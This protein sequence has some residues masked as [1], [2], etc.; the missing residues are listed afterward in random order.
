[1]ELNGEF[2]ILMNRSDDKK[3]VKNFK[4]VFGRSL[5]K[6]SDKSMLDAK[7]PFTFKYFYFD[8]E[9]AKALYIEIEPNQDEKGTF[10]H[11]GRPDFGW[12]L[13]YRIRD[14]FDDV[15]KQEVATLLIKNIKLLTFKTEFIRHQE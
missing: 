14:D 7:L 4:D 12:I 11:P 2:G 13:R 10:Q 15:N 6:S 9:K 1:M 8:F 3:F 5:S